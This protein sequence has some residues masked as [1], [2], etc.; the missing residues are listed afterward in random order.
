MGKDECIKA[1]HRFLQDIGINIKSRGKGGPTTKPK[2][3]TT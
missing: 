2:S 1:L 3:H